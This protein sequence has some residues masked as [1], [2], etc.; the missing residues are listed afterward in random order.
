M[1]R[2]ALPALALGLAPI[3]AQ[4]QFPGYYP[5][6]PRPVP[7]YAPPH[8]HVVRHAPPVYTMDDFAK[9]FR[10]TEGHHRIWIVHPCSNR[11][12]EVCF[13]LPCG[14]LREVEVNRHSIEFE[15]SSA[16]D[17]RLVF[18]HNGTVSVR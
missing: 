10:P 1:F 11:P 2:T 13:T 9:C 12:V 14:R 16:R 6:Q 15:Y 4:A 3:P 17:V 8:S 7:V 18:H 5:S